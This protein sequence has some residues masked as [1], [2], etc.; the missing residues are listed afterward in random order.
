MEAAWGLDL[1]THG[2]GCPLW[3]EASQLFRWLE[4]DLQQQHLMRK[5]C[6]LD[7]KETAKASN[8]C[9]CQL[10]GPALFSL[11]AF[12]KKAFQRINGVS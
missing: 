4:E 1:D 5:A 11:T 3:E 7:L 2:C 8:G 6:D 12:R 9:C 10:S